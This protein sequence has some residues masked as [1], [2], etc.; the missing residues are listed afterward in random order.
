MMI[1]GRQPSRPSSA[2]EKPQTV[3]KRTGCA[4]W[5]RQPFNSL[6]R[7]FCPCSLTLARRPRK[8]RAIDPRPVTAA[9]TGRQAAGEVQRTSTES[10]FYFEFDPYTGDFLNDSGSRF[11]PGRGHKL[12]PM[13]YYRYR[14]QQR[15]R[16]AMVESLMLAGQLFQEYMCMAFI[17]VETQNLAWLRRPSSQKIL[18]AECYAVLRQAV[19][20]ADAVD[21]AA[22][23][24]ANTTKV[25]CGKV[26]PST[27]NGSRRHFVNKY[28]EAMATVAAHGKPSL[29]ITFTANANWKAMVDACGATVPPC[30][31][32]ERDDLM[33]RVFKLQLDELLADLTERHVLG[34][35]VAYLHVVEYQQRG[36]PHAHILVI[37]ASTARVHRSADADDIVTAEIPEPPRR[38]AY[39]N[40]SVETQQRTFETAYAT[41]LRLKTLV[42]GTMLHR[43][44]GPGEP[45]WDAVK[46]R[47]TKGFPKAFCQETI[48]NTD[49]SYPQYRRRRPVPDLR[50][51]TPLVSARSRERERLVF[52]V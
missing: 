48:W 30:K 37:F 49:T 25:R 19:E 38:D 23:G 11:S 7:R 33:A 1:I 16:G 24:A 42:V 27:F 3:A 32:S 21:V 18:R 14:L 6:R 34:R 51:C 22:G 36:Y 15:G 47:C 2:A 12:T 9:R 20:D 13:D 29:F 43:Q 17:K 5:S 28:R 35:V 26:L 45:C 50:A 4:P 46:N 10:K 8:G 41:W 40:G 39:T 31:P 44:C 52:A